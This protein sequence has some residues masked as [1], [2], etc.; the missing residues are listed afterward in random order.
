MGVGAALNV[1]SDRVGRV[2]VMA[3]ATV[4]LAAVEV[5][6]VVLAKMPAGTSYRWLYVAYTL[7]GLR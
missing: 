6:F 2:R 1:L 3:Y 7:D 5:V 4:V